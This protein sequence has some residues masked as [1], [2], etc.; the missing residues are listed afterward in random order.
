MPSTTVIEM[1]HQEQVQTLTAVR[2]ALIPLIAEEVSETEIAL[3]GGASHGSR[4]KHHRS[5][6]PTRLPR[7]QNIKSTHKEIADKVTISAAAITT[8]VYPRHENVFMSNHTP[9]NAMLRH[10]GRHNPSSLSRWRSCSHPTA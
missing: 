7:E 10:A 9:C 6:I 8:H 5:R 1:S 3:R 4:G 2:R